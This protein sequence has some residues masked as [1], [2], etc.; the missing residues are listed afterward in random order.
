MHRF[1]R[2]VGFS[3][4][5]KRQEIKGLLERIQENPGE[6][7]V[8]QADD[9][10]RMQIYTDTGSGIGISVY[11]ELNERDEM[12]RDYYFPFL[13]STCISTQAPCQIQ[14]HAEKES[15]SG[16]CEEYRV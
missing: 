7:Q 14:R 13:R 12:E 1:L 10:T 11:G 8:V 2:A 16:I 9:G 15:Y 5:T 3:E 4:Y 6:I